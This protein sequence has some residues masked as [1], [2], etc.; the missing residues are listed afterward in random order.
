VLSAPGMGVAELLQ[1]AVGVESAG[2]EEPP[3]ACM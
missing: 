3:G 2:T 1:S